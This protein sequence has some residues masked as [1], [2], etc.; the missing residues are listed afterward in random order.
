MKLFMIEQKNWWKPSIWFV[1]C[2]NCWLFLGTK[3]GLLMYYSK[4]MKVFAFLPCWWWS[5]FTTNPVHE[6]PQCIWFAL[7]PFKTFCHQMTRI[8]TP[9][10]LLLIRQLETMTSLASFQ[11]ANPPVLY[12][13]ESESGRLFLIGGLLSTSAVIPR[14]RYLSQIQW[15]HH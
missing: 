13:P 10:W 11:K 5:L 14:G 4:W 15:K 7:F 12:C 2:V 8:S 6:L 9:G 3:S 1:G